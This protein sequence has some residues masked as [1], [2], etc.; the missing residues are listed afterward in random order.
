MRLAPD[1]V[2]ST[3]IAWCIE[4]HV[5]VTVACGRCGHAEQWD[6]PA[7]QQRFAGREWLWMEAVASR[8]RC[9]AC[10]SREGAVGGLAVALPGAA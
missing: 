8:L 7:L 2:S 3:T 9:E 5:G 6:P 10:G 1:L 4:N